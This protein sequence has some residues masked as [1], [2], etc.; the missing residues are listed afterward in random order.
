MR[1]LEDHLKFLE[2][3]EIVEPLKRLPS[4]L[5]ICANGSCLFP[6]DNFLFSFLDFWFILT[7]F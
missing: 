1:K 2:I 5:S 7:I 3:L 6:N 4:E